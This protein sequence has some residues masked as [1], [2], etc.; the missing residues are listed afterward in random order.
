VKFYKINLI[1]KIK[2]KHAIN[3][4][5]HITSLLNSL[6]TKE[7]TTHGVRNPGPGFGQPHKCGGVKPVN[8]IPAISSY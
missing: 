3:I 4:N 2:L 8:G 6:H 5:N 7:T 1:L